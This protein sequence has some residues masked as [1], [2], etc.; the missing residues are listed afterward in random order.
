MNI[1]DF[2]EE[3]VVDSLTYGSVVYNIEECGM[4]WEGVAAVFPDSWQWM[5]KRYEEGIESGY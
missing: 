1:L 3:D 2:N 5:K 4:N